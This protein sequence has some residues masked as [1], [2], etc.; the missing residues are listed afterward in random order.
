MCAHIETT[1][2]SPQQI[3]YG[4]TTT[5]AAVSLRLPRRVHLHS[6]AH[7]CCSASAVSDT[8]LNH[9][10]PHHS[11]QDQQDDT[12]HNVGSQALQPRG[13]LACT[14]SSLLAPLGS[15][16]VCWSLQLR[17]QWLPCKSAESVIFGWGCIKHTLQVM[18]SQP[19]R[20]AAVMH[21]P[22]ASTHA[23]RACAKHTLEPPICV[24]CNMACPMPWP[25]LFCSNKFEIYLRAPFQE[26][27]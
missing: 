9:V 10:R 23:V 8:R 5:T 18:S 3:M 7:L 6:H 2:S 12:D 26:Q 4:S 14:P 16:H 13:E 15:R 1:H 22:Q 25:L 21:M 17:G 20:D 27:E 11:H 24:A 19:C